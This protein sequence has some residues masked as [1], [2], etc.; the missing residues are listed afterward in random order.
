MPIKSLALTDSP[1][2]LRVR[3]L[4]LKTRADV[5]ALLDVSLKQLTYHLFVVSDS[6]R[7]T[8]FNIAKRSGAIVKSGAPQQR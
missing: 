4:A 7:Y 1:D 8:K 5:A 3:F 2:Q 6:E